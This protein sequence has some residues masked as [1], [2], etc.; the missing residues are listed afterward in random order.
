M[1]DLGDEE[2][3]LYNPQVAKRALAYAKPY[4]RQLCITL[5]LTILAAA[6]NLT[7]PYLV[8]IAIDE[9][10]AV[11]DFQGL[12]IIIVLTLGVYVA[13]YFAVL[14]ESIIEHLNQFRYHPRSARHS[15]AL[16]ILIVEGLLSAYPLL[17]QRASEGRV[18]YDVN[19]DL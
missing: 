18:V 2:G 14:R 16:G 17:K 1:R 8:K 6:L 13:Q 7:A 12:T 5:A 9:H 15:N 19:M 3:A 4:Q 11:G 10:I